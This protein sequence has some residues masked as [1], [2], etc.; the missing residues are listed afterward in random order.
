MA[1]GIVGVLLLLLL[2][3]ASLWAIGVGKFTNPFAVSAQIISPLPDDYQSLPHPT[4]AV[5]NPVA[6]VIASGLP[7]AVAQALAGTKGSYGVVVKN[8]DTRET[9]GLNEHRVYETASLYKLWVMAEVVGRI[10]SGQ[11]SGEKRLTDD[12]SS[13]NRSFSISDEVAEL[14]SGSITMT[15]N[16][17]LEQMITISHN[18]AALLLTK[19]IRLSSVGKFLTDNGFSESKVG[20][21]DH[22]PLSTAADISR[23]YEK[24]L[25]GELGDPDHTEMM[26]GLLK[27][28]KLNNKLPKYLPLGTVIAH[29]TGEL[30]SF[31]HDA[32]I[33]YTPK[34]D[35]Y[36]IVVMSESS[37]PPAAED[38]IAR[39]SQAV[40]DY[41]VRN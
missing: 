15:I 29:K 19:H 24:L 6:S 2:L 7:A 8:L 9:F 12:I 13:L 26:L 32:G 31:T 10:Q 38:R 27:N 16:Q 17:A 30:N 28:Q 14:I 22:N 40:Y 3:T 41:F 35:K 11:L 34:G 20:N 4:K 1:R 5:K 18:Y 33:V 25:T 36:I 37:D 23:F 21:S 39:V